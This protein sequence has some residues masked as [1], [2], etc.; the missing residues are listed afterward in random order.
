MADIQVDMELEEDEGTADQLFDS[1]FDNWDDQEQEMYGQNQYADA[2][3]SHLYWPTIPQTLETNKAYSSEDDNEAEDSKHSSRFRN[4]RKK[5]YFNTG[6]ISSINNKVNP[7]GSIDPVSKGGFVQQSALGQKDKL[8][9]TLQAWINEN[10]KTKGE[11]SGTSGQKYAFEEKYKVPSIMAGLIIGKGGGTIREI[12]FKSGAS[13]QLENDNG[14]EKIF[15]IK[16]NPMQIKNAKV[17]IEALPNQVRDAYI[18]KPDNQPYTL[19]EWKYMKSCWFFN[20]Q[21]RQCHK[22]AFDCKK[23]HRCCICWDESHGKMNCPV[24]STPHQTKTQNLECSDLIVTG[25]LPTMTDNELLEYFKTFGRVYH[26]QVIKDNLTGQNNGTAKVKFVELTAQK[27]VLAYKHVFKGHQLTVKNKISVKDRLGLNP[28][29]TITNDLQKNFQNPVAGTSSTMSI[30]QYSVPAPALGNYSL[31]LPGGNTYGSYTGVDYSNYNQIPMGIQK[32]ELSHLGS[33]NPY[34]GAAIGPYMKTS[35]QMIQGNNYGLNQP[36]SSHMAALPPV[37]LDAT[38]AT[39]AASVED[40]KN[41]LE[42]ARIDAKSITEMVQ[43]KKVENLLKILDEQCKK[44]VSKRSCSRSKSRSR[45]KSLS[46]SRRRHRSRK[47]VKRG[48]RKRNR[49]RS[50]SPSSSSYDSYSRSH[51]RSRSR[52]KASEKK[53]SVF[54]R[55]GVPK[56][57]SIKDRLGLNPNYTPIKKSADIEVLVVNDSKK[58]SKDQNYEKKPVLKKKST[59]QNYEKKHD[60]KKKSTDQTNEK[61]PVFSRLGDTEKI[62]DKD[63]LILNTN[64]SAA[65]DLSEKEVYHSKKNFRDDLGDGKQNGYLNW[66]QSVANSDGPEKGCVKDRYSLNT[67]TSAAYDLNQN[68]F[69]NPVTGTGSAEVINQFLVPPPSI[70][71]SQ[72]PDGVTYGSYTGY[73]NYNQI[74]MGGTPITSNPQNMSVSQLP[75]MGYAPPYQGIAS[76]SNVP[77][78]QGIPSGSNAPPYQGIT[79]GSNM[80]ATCYQNTQATNYGLNPTYS[81]HATALPPLMAGATSTASV[82]DAD[83]LKK[84]EDLLKKLDEQQSKINASRRYSRS[85]SKSKSIISIYS[86]SRSRSPTRYRKKRGGRDRSRSNSISQSRRRNISRSNSRGRRNRSKSRSL[87]KSRIYRYRSRSR[88]KSRDNRSRD[89][90]VPRKVSK[91]SRSKSWDRK[92]KYM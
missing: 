60:L 12:M 71:P 79:S 11:T 17:L 13:I 46:S 83:R 52:S 80:N 20:F 9:L 72:L 50:R 38:I 92:Y 56:N 8:N 22:S 44:N 7:H 82:D 64:P 4:E 32:T 30:N 53:G 76:G 63:F 10:I 69:R 65:N 31:Q 18:P 61:K 58:K 90:F 24:R 1:I 66:L 23:L 87:S 35:N 81:S 26:V 49:S 5:I 67:K 51:S 41:I 2:N 45:S 39:A 25:L 70:Y 88:S 33:A 77:P 42:K 59:D 6:H 75:H 89:Q 43:L 74:A 29:S 55:I 54:S 36:S 68:L 57:V 78:Y 48:R 21:I 37:V 16:G 19:E 34:Q 85:I 27:R 91:R 73:N 40:A 62:N 47:R 86:R 15:T 84:V 3:L 28:K 14:S